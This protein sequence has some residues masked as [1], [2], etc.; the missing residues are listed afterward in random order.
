M[1]KIPS[2]EEIEASAKYQQITKDELRAEQVA[3]EKDRVRL[4]Q[5]MDELMKIIDDHNRAE[6]TT[7][8]TV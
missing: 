1:A 8:E 2:L 4:I 3:V 7:E 6:Q 5:K